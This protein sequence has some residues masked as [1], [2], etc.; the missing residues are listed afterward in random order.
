MQC[1][2]GPLF[3]ITTSRGMFTSFAWKMLL[4]KLR[5]K[6]CVVDD[7]KCAT[8]FKRLAVAGLPAEVD[9]NSLGLNDKPPEHCDADRDGDCNHP[10]C[11]QRRDNEPR[12]TG[13]SC[14]I[15]DWPEE[16]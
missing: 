11:P 10:G 2:G 4:H 14:P 3:I 16:A 5:T 9:Y 6:D 1:Q 15:P 13:R 12:A 7:L 8:L